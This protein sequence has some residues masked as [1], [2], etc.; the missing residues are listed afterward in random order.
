MAQKSRH[1]YASVV[2]ATAL[3]MWQLPSQTRRN[4]DNIHGCLFFRRDGVSKQFQKL[5]T[6]TLKVLPSFIGANYI[7]LV[8]PNPHME[9]VNGYL[10]TNFRHIVPHIVNGER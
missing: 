4:E 5:F 2:Y 7:R 1:L 8:L 3:S 10:Q 6:R 9:H